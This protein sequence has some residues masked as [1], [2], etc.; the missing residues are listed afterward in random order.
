[1]QSMNL[2]TTMEVDSEDEG[3][4]QGYPGMKGGCYQLAED[5][6]QQVGHIGKLS[7]EKEETARI[8]KEETFLI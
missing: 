7:Q 5:E 3:G 4:G 1:M 6:S 8:R 2:S